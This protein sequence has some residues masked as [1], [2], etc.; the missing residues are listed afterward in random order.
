[1][2][3]MKNDTLE[4]R[5]SENESGP[6]LTGVINELA[7][8]ALA[9]TGSSGLVLVVEANGHE[10]VLQQNNL[11]LVSQSN[12]P[13]GLTKSIVWKVGKSGHQLSVEQ[14]WQL[15][16]PVATSSVEVTNNGSTVIKVRDVVL[17]TATTSA[18][19]DALKVEIKEGVGDPGRFISKAQGAIDAN[20]IF[21]QDC[22]FVGID[23]PVAENRNDNGQLLCRQFPGV[24]LK[25]NTSWVS[26]TL[27]IGVSAPG[28][29]PQAFLKHLDVKRGRPTRRAS[30]YFDWLTHA[31]EGPTQDE[32]R[33]ML[34]Y[35]AVLRR[36]YGV[37]F[38]LYA[39]DDGAV[40]TRWELMYDRH[41]LRHRTLYPDGLKPLAARAKE[42]GMEMGIWLGPDVIYRGD[43]TD[44][45]RRD[46]ILNMVRDWNVGIFKLD[47]CVSWA[48]KDDPYYNDWYMTKL[49]ELYAAARAINPKLVVINHRIRFSPYMLTVLDST[50]WESAESY[51]EIMLGN[52]NMPRLYTRYG[53]YQRGEPTYYGGYSPLLEDHGMCF[54]G[55]WRGWRNEFV[56]GAFGRAL[57]LS[58]EIYGTMFL[59]PDYELPELGRLMKLAT[60]NR[61][62]LGHT[63]YLPTGDFVHSDGKAC[64]VCV[65][66]NSW[67][68]CRRTLT[69]ADL[70]L[71]A[72]HA[73]QVELLYPQDG[74]CAVNDAVGA[75]GTLDV[76][77]PAFGIAAVKVTLGVGRTVSGAPQMQADGHEGPW[78]SR[79]E[80]LETVRLSPS[81]ACT[82][83]DS[84]NTTLQAQVEQ[85]KF[86]V[87]SDP[88]EHQ[89]WKLLMTSKHPE[90]NAC[91]DFFEG[92]LHRESTGI[93]AHAWDG[94]PLTVWG[95]DGVWRKSNNIWRVDLKQVS[96]I[97]MVEIQLSQ[98]MPGP[99]L[100]S[101]EKRGL[102]EPIF[103]D[104]STDLLNWTRRPA[105][106]FYRRRPVEPDSAIQIIADFG[107]TAGRYV[108]IH[109]R[110]FYCSAIV[111]RT[112]DNKVIPSHGWHGN[113]VLT[114]RAPAH[115]GTMDLTAGLKN[116]SAES[117]LAV[118]CKFNAEFWAF[119]ELV[120]AWLTCGDEVI[121]L[122]ESSPMLPSHRWEWDN[123]LRINAFT[124]RY[125]LPVGA[126]EK[127][128]KNGK[129]HA[130]VAVFGAEE[131]PGTESR[132]TIEAMIVPYLVR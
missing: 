97:G 33:K 81:T 2:R 89:A 37:Q 108:R 79:R 35:L 104:V 70:G 112:P 18:G 101:G 120:L 26:Q 65:I 113:N 25:P 118:V 121:P 73:Y 4:L 21:L 68:A 74:L 88:F 38:D 16:G 3:G 11:D 78:P 6:V 96:T 93:A 50:L 41:Q 31:T 91:R 14:T 109:T 77:L 115:Y 110:G 125:D 80:S 24:E 124:F 55:D 59:L 63:R 117:T 45:Q 15:N 83:W 28:K 95:D 105:H 23:W 36:D 39:L 42:L 7:N 128:L 123:C 129:V 52:S 51:P 54:N 131:E 116:I 102:P 43:V 99:V 100:A 76:A 87:D 114:S 20:P 132:P 106:V 48:L 32:T 9:F 47:V 44:T 53:A 85:V 126:V 71:A 46:D 82:P 84:T 90:V 69:L 8:Q 94:N 19:G 61:E 49:A 86:A 75:G 17:L 127:L 56:L 27:S 22:F 5:F 34:D 60:A 119:R 72:D 40:E 130:H 29:L 92:K 12:S 103:M 98:I 30:F 67:D 107:G 66:N 1:M 122:L 13:D 10:S 57:A 58:P 111:V 62:L 64:L